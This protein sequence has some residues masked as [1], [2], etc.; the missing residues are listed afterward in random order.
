MPKRKVHQVGTKTLKSSSQDSP[1]YVVESVDDFSSADQVSFQC[2]EC[3][4]E[5]TWGR[6][7]HELLNPTHHPDTSIKWVS[8]R[9]FLCREKFFNVIY[10][11]MQYEKHA[12]PREPGTRPTES[13][14]P[15]LAPYQAVVGVMKIGQYPAPSVALPPALSKNLGPDAAELSRKGLQCRNNGY[16]LAA[17]SYIH[18]VVEDKTNELIEVAAKLADFPWRRHR[19]VVGEDSRRREFGRIHCIRRKAEDC[20]HSVSG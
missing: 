20:G 16:G 9:C 4:K 1:L 10:K 11:E 14:L 5:T 19:A 3:G 8:F 12:M 17:V 2:D 15:P 13:V 6:I 18:Q 7:S